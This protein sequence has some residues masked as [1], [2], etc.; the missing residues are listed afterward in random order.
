M[1]GLREMTFRNLRVPCV[2]RQTAGALDRKGNFN[3]S[4]RLLPDPARYEVHDL[5]GGTKTLHQTV[6]F[7]SGA[8]FAFEPAQKSTLTI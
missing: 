2:G 5:S 7:V 8:Y 4:A 3:L 1:L 6:K